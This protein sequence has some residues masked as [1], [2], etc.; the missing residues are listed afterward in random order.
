VMDPARA[1]I[2]TV[3]SIIQAIVTNTHSCIPATIF[4]TR[5]MPVSMGFTRWVVMVEF[6]TIP[7]TIRFTMEDSGMS[8]AIAIAKMA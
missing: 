1:T 5:P 2:Q 8:S 4:M 3:N 7:I 6:P